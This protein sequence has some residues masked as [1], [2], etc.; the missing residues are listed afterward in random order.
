MLAVG[1][2]YL[3]I[4]FGLATVALFAVVVIVFQYLIGALLIS[5]QRADELELRGQAAGRLPGRPARAPCCAPSTCA[6]G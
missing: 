4:Q 2:A 5:Q 3:Y 6:I 1:I